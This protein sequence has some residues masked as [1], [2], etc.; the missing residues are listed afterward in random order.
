MT[1]PVPNGIV[2]AV[3]IILFM[4]FMTG[5]A[6]KPPEVQTRLVEVPSSKPY[7]FITYTPE[8]PET[9]ARQIRRHNRSHQEVI[10][11]EKAA[12]AKK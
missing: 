7:R 10:S 11:A 12:A 1:R 4:I 2:V 3:V 5:C 6:A 9:V 8:T